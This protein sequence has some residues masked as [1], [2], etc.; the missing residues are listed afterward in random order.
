MKQVGISAEGSDAGK[1]LVS[2]MKYQQCCRVKGE[3]C[4]PV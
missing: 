4:S 2:V 3:F 1:L